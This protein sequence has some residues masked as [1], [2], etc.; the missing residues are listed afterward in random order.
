MAIPTKSKIAG[1]LNIPVKKAKVVL[2][3]SKNIAINRCVA[4]VASEDANTNQT[5]IIPIKDFND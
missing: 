4:R 1:Q 2:N 5:I 3:N